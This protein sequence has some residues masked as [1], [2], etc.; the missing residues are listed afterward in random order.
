MIYNYVYDVRDR[1][2]KDTLNVLIPCVS[3]STYFCFEVIKRYEY[4]FHTDRAGSAA[5]NAPIEGVPK[6]LQ[7]PQKSVPLPR[8]W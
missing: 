7:G 4:V 8:F 5:L 6:L 2:W 1:F 3:F